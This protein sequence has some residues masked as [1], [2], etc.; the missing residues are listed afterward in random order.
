[1][2]D[3]ETASKLLR[4]LLLLLVAMERG[5]PGGEVS[6]GTP[7]PIK[8]FAS[9][10]LLPLLLLRPTNAGDPTRPRWLC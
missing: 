7:P 8:L 9:L 5:E 4:L 10:L 3:C 1:M 2:T 6:I